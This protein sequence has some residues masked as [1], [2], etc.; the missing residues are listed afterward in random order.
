[1]AYSTSGYRTIP[2]IIRTLLEDVFEQQ[3]STLELYQLAIQIQRNEILAAGLGV[4]QDDSRP[5][6]IEN[7]SIEIREFKE[8]IQP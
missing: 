8:A 4:A 6:F 2:H 5:S 7:L 1:M 3:V